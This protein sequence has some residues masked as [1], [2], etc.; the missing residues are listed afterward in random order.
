[1]VS[2]DIIVPA[3][4]Q[5]KLVIVAASPEWVVTIAPDPTTTYTLDL[6]GRLL[7][8]PIVGPVRTS[9]RKK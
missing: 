6:R 4:H 1:M 7:R 5:L 9:N 8:I 3:G 2:N